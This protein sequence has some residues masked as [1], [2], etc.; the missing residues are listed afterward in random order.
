MLVKQLVLRA[1]LHI[2]TATCEMIKTCY[3][4][5][6][7]SKGMRVEKVAGNQF[8]KESRTKDGMVTV[9]TATVCH[10]KDLLYVDP[11]SSHL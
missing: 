7:R 8:S 5:G 1:R 4:F 6:G 3:C 2:A 9:H 10:S 11:R